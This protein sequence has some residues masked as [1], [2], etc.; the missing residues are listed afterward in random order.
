MTVVKSYGTRK[1]NDDTHGTGATPGDDESD[2]ILD[3][4]TTR[5]MRNAAELEAIARAYGTH[6]FRARRKAG[7][8]DWLIGQYIL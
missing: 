1:M 7:G 8:P 3:S 2:L 4:L 5:E 6:I